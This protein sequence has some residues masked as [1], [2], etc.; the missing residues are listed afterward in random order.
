SPVGPALPSGVT[1]LRKL[2]VWRTK[3]PFSS[4]ACTGCQ[5]AIHFPLTSIS[6]SLMSLRAGDAPGIAQE[7]A[8][9]TGVGLHP[10]L[11]GARHDSLDVGG[12]SGDDL[13]RVEPGHALGPTRGAA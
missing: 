11:S 6:V 3:P 2:E 5:L 9:D 10:R 12:V 13:H 8:F 1:Q 4:L 7:R